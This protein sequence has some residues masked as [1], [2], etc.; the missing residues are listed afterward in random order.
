MGFCNIYQHN[1]HTA[2]VHKTVAATLTN[3]FRNRLWVTLNSLSKSVWSITCIWLKVLISAEHQ[4]VICIGLG[5][6]L[7]LQM[8]ERYKEM[9]YIHMMFKQNYKCAKKKKKTDWKYYGPIISNRLVQNPHDHLWH[10][11][12]KIFQAMSG[13]SMCLLEP[14][15]V[16]LQ[17]IGWVSHHAPHLLIYALVNELGSWERGRPQVQ[18]DLNSNWNTKTMLLFLN[19]L[20][21]CDSSYIVVTIWILHFVICGEQDLT[22]TRGRVLN[23]DSSTNHLFFKKAG[24]DILS[25]KVEYS[26]Q[27]WICKIGN[28]LNFWL[29]CSSLYKLE[30]WTTVTWQMSMNLYL[31]PTWCVDGNATLKWLFSLSSLLL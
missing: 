23:K 24:D 18:T 19:R 31:T 21:P 29:S 30:R 3:T 4:R 7:S 9:L 17:F 11:V 14:G 12:A 28:I 25:K 6:F 10:R 20:E 26:L 22:S 15:S 5:W 13:G 1:F 27:T 8:L 16:T 2:D